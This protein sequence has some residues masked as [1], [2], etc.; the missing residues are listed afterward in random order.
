MKKLWE[1]WRRVW[2]RQWVRCSEAALVGIS[3]QKPHTTLPTQL[4][5]C[6]QKPRQR[7]VVSPWGWAEFQLSQFWRNEISYFREQPIP[8][9]FTHWAQRS[10]S[11]D[12]CWP[13]I[14][15]NG[16]L[17]RPMS[18]EISREM[19]IF[20]LTIWVSYISRERALPHSTYERSLL[21]LSKI[22]RTVLNI[23][24]R[25][26]SKLRFKRGRYSSQCWNLV[27]L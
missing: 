1:K 12:R 24:D 25:G 27:C 18:D 2:P 11:N 19:R 14:L 21:R 8:L 6:V 23:N 3:T 10:G 26:V 7:N 17:K 4:P 22:Y 15:E 5:S 13:K 16:N 9:R 20:T